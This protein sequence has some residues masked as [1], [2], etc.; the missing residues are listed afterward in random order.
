MN[1]TIHIANMEFTLDD[2]SYQ[3]LQDYLDSIRIYFSTIESGQEIVDDI[4]CRIA[5]LLNDHMQTN[6]QIDL[7]AVSG[8]IDKIGKPEDFFP[9][10]ENGNTI[11]GSMRRAIRDTDEVPEV[12]V[13]SAISWGLKHAFKPFWTLLGMTLLLVIIDIPKS[14]AINMTELENAGDISLRLALT[15][16]AIFVAFNLLIRPVFEAGYCFSY[17][18]VVRKIP[19]NF[20]LF[21]AFVQNQ[22]WITLHDITSLPPNLQHLG[23]IST[24]WCRGSSDQLCGAGFL[25]YW[26]LSF[27]QI[28][29]RSELNRPCNS[30]NQNNKSQ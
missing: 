18:T 22:S 8:A 6:D 5:E 1:K 12:G 11:K 7:V 4:N 29:I 24:R 27:E 26:Y 23:W 13:F 20:G 30:K 3:V 2:N 17:L 15:I 14:L 25:R 21:L 28:G 19:V 10:T 9:I 16:G